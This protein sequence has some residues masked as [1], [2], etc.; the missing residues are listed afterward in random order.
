MER[1]ILSDILAELKINSHTNERVFGYTL[2]MF[3][4]KS[5]KQQPICRA[6]TPYLSFQFHIL[7]KPPVRYEFLWRNGREINTTWF[8]K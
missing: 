2:L 8:Y 7:F 6:K 1:E 5:S 4:E 3:K